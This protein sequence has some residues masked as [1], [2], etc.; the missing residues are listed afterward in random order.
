MDEAVLRVVAQRLTGVVRA[1]Y[2]SCDD[3]NEPQQECEDLSSRHA[4]AGF[5]NMLWTKRVASYRYR[6]GRYFE[7]G[8]NE[9][10]RDNGSSG[11]T[12]QGLGQGESQPGIL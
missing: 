10:R 8:M 6:S 2:L 9:H 7:H 11:I 4:V 1:P 5:R 12:L 3:A